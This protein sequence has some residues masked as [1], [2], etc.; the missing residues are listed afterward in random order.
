[1]YRQARELMRAGADLERARELLE[2]AA[3]ID[4]TCEAVYLLGEW[5]LT[6]GRPD[7]ALL[8]FSRYMDIDPTQVGSYLKSAAILEQRGRLDEARAVLR[9]GLEYVTA[10]RERQV[11]RPDPAVAA[12]YNSKAIGTYGA[13]GESVERLS[14]E[15]SRLG[16]P[17][18]R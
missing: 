2:R 16:E 7:E 14:A 6:A 12:R 18:P 9:R 8:Q 10:E 5:Y 4:P 17:A 1:M 3:A 11:P 15:L 13:Y